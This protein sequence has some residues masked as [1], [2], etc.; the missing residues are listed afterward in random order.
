MKRSIMPLMALLEQCTN[1]PVEKPPMLQK[2]QN[3]DERKKSQ[4]RFV[5]AMNRSRDS[6]NGTIIYDD[7]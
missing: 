7:L 2:E 6:L 3:G 5:R 1:G 4:R